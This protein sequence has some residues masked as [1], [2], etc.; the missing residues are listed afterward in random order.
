MTDTTPATPADTTPAKTTFLGRMRKAL[1]AGV[2]GAIGGTGLVCTAIGAS[3]SFTPDKL[4]NDI[5]LIAIG[6]VG[7]FATAFAGAWAAKPNDPPV[8]TTTT[9]VG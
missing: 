9:S 8:S 5:W 4:G 3:G 7:G 1:G 2:G 6:A